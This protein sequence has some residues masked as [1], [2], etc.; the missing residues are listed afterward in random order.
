[1]RCDEVIRELAVPTDDRDS[2]SAGRASGELSV[3]A[4]AG[5]N[6]TRN[7]IVSGTRRDRRNPRLRSGTR[8]WAHVAS[9]LDILDASASLRRSHAARGDLEW[10]SG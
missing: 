9:S 4:P 7:S 5:P 6:V 2:A 8:V 1:M 3:R 10:I